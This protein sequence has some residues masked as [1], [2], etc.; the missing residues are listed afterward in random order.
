MTSV[1]EP[2]FGDFTSKHSRY[3]VVPPKPANV[4][5]K[6]PANNHTPGELFPPMLKGFNKVD[7]VSIRKAI[8]GDVTMD[9]IRRID[10]LS[11]ISRCR[12]AGF[13]PGK[14]VKRATVLEGDRVLHGV[15]VCYALSD[16][17]LKGYFPL[18][19]RWKHPKKDYEWIG[20]Y[21]RDDLEL[22]DE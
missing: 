3:V 17:E 19:V 4:E 11:A 18:I 1:I 2:L 6:P 22:D 21:S 20:F 7:Q 16:G 12:E 14:K 9:R 5:T 15:I 10:R 13:L 8:V